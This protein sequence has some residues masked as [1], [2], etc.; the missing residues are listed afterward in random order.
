MTYIVVDVC[1]ECTDVRNR[2]IYKKIEK[3]LD[4]IVIVSIQ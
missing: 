4:K 3:Y 2:K 1:Y